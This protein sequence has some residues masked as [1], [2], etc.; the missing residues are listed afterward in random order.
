MLLEISLTIHA[1]LR[2]FKTSKRNYYGRNMAN[3]VF[4]IEVEQK[5]NV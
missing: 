4:Q 3:L 1:V 5:H 2:D